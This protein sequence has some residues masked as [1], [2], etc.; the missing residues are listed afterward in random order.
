MRLAISFARKKNAFFGP[1]D[2]K[3]WMLKFQGEV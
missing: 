3:L 2:Q 1:M